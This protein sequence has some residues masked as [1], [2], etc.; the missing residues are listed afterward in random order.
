[1]LLFPCS[2]ECLPPSAKVTPC[3]SYILVLYLGKLL[4][5][6]LSLLVVTELS[7]YDTVLTLISHWKYMYLSQCNLW[8]KK[9]EKKCRCSS[10]NVFSFFSLRLPR[11]TNREVQPSC[12]SCSEIVSLS[13]VWVVGSMLKQSLNDQVHGTWMLQGL[14]DRSNMTPNFLIFL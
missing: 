13:L 3:Y 4:K 8:R 6:I 5:L 2:A 1:M 12:S 10:A 9:R 14:F 11:W 7:K